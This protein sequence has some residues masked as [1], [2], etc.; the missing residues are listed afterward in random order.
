[1][2]TQTS[3]E[4]FSRDRS[5]SERE[6]VELERLR[7]ALQESELRYRTTLNSLG[8]A[9]HIV[10]TN[11]RITFFNTAFILW[12][13]ALGLPT[14]VIGR[15]VFE[16]FPFLSDKVVAEYERVVKSG[17]TLITEE[18]TRIGSQEYIT[19]ARKI[20]IIRD[21]QVCEVVTAIRN[22]TDVRRTEETL[23]RAEKWLEQLSIELLNAKEDERKRISFEIHDRIGQSLAAIKYRA[24][25]A[26]KDQAAAVSALEPVIG[27]VRTALS[28]MRRIELNLQPP[29]LIDSGLEAAV[30]HLCDELE[31]TY[32]GIQFDRLTSLEN[33][34]YPEFLKVAIYRILQESLSNVA[35]HSQADRVRILLTNSEGPLELTVSDNGVGFNVKEML[36]GAKT[37]RG[38]GLS[39]M[40]ERATL[41]GG[42]FSIESDKASGTTVHVV[43]N[44]K[45]G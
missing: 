45:P 38:L 6:S 26:L 19:E 15:S 43:W 27:I 31:D 36:A 12:D 20:P 8:D 29:V 32:S 7:A 41:S 1:M 42:T 2:A 24:E 30:T 22:L 35:T 9:I 25:A 17:K 39:S 40:N 28:E 34:Q 44:D 23:E 14:D 5:D 11:W 13:A 33:E 37:K 10:D 21:G 16:V 18:T 3:Q 4:P